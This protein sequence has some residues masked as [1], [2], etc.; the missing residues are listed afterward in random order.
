M[1]MFYTVVITD[2]S[3]K[4]VAEKDFDRYA[5]AEKWT[6]KKLDKIDD[7]YAMGTITKCGVSTGYND[8]F[9]TIICK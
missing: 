3:G 2:A 6:R 4:F 9:V 8:E 5:Q 1:K 7:C